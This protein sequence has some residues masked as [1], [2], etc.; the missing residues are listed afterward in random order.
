MADYET[1]ALNLLEG[2]GLVMSD[3]YKAYR[4]PLYPLMI[5]IV[6]YLGGISPENMY[7]L[8]CGLSILTVWLVYLFTY[9]LFTPSP[10]PADSKDNESKQIKAI[11]KARTIAFL[12]AAFFC[13]EETSIFFCGQMLT[14]TLFTFLFVIWG[15]LLIRGVLSPNLLLATV[16]GIIGGLAILT[17]PNFAPLV[18]IGASWFLKAS[19]RYYTPPPTDWHHFHLLESPFAPPFVMVLYTFLI[20]SFWTMRNQAVLG[21]F[22]PV[23]TNSGVNFYLGHHEDFGYNSFGNKEGIRQQLRSQGSYN[24]V[25][26]SK[27]FSLVASHFI[28]NHPWE[29]LKN[30][31]SKIDHLYLAPA[32]LQSAIEPWKWWSY[33]DSPYRPWPWET[34]QRELRFWPIRDQEGNLIMPSHKKYF[35]QEG[36]LP[37]IFWNW[38]M[39]FLTVA[40]IFWS[41]QHR[42]RIRLPI[43]VILVYTLILMVY[44]ANARFRA[45]LLPFLYPFTAYTLVSLWERIRG[46]SKRE[47]PIEHN[48]GA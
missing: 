41:R 21:E 1:M 24:E 4:P 10:L 43:Y 30:N 9:W 46:R 39:I 42:E 40:G 19:R 48:S 33:L 15:Y 35:W 18:L 31:L 7:L 20:V 25:I 5:A 11:H 12:T 22:V 36:R 6:Y 34:Q 16:V 3:L 44:F 38:P 37:L 27:Y 13:F 29:D 8:Q 2:R 26:E 23:S 17:R 32:S 45:P 14:E 28:R 47:S